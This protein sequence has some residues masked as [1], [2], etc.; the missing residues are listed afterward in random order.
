MA[1][2]RPFAAS[3]TEMGFAKSIQ[4]L[5]DAGI[6]SC[7]PA[8]Y[9][10][11]R[12]SADNEENKRRCGNEADDQTGAR[13]KLNPALVSQIHGFSPVEQSDFGWDWG[14]SFVPAGPG[15]P[16]TCCN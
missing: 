11:S 15:S 3:S 16:P 12:V 10:C 6:R 8:P 5:F 2:M 9:G 4:T 7:N 1:M 13:R 14:P